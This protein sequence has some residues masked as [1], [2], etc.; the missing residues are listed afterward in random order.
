[1]SVY[2]FNYAFISGNSVLKHV[3]ISYNVFYVFYLLL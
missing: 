2:S 1:M 3:M